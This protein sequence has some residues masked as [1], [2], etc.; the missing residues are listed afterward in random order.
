ML[1]KL[2]VN[3]TNLLKL[4]KI[5]SASTSYRKNTFGNCRTATNKNMIE[6]FFVIKFWQKSEKSVNYKEKFWDLNKGLSF[7]SGLKNFP[8]WVFQEAFLRFRY[9][10]LKKHMLSRTLV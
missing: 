10:L 3:L 2:G 5:N 1:K 4:A 8:V 6:K 9:A 7:D